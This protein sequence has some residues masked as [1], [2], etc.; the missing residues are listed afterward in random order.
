MAT[1]ATLRDRLRFQKI[2]EA[3]TDYYTDEILLSMLVE[4]S[5]EIAGALMIPMLEY[6]GSLVAGATVIEVPNSPRK[7]EHVSINKSRVGR[8]SRSRVEFYQGL[9]VNNFPRGWTYD[10]RVN[11][12]T[13]EFGPPLESDG[14]CWVKYVGDY[15]AGGDPAATD[16][17]WDGDF[18]EFEEAIVLLAASKAA[19]MGQ[20]YDDAQHHLGRAQQ[21][22][23]LFAQD[24]GRPEPTPTEG[25]A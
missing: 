14:E 4:A 16:S 17:P 22:L 21:V 10:N 23:A 7:V 19:E 25:K 18:P 1:F 13:V 3:A 15:F 20:E 2:V 11:G 24:L 8:T 12:S 5:R 9:A 6:Q